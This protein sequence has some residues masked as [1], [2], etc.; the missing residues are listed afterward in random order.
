VSLILRRAPV[1]VPGSPLPAIIANGEYRRLGVKLSDRPKVAIRTFRDYLAG[2]P[3]L[4]LATMQPYDLPVVGVPIRNQGQLGDCVCNALISAV[5]EE[6]LFAGQTLQA[7]SPAALY[8]LVNGGSDNGSDPRDAITEWQSKGLCLASDVPPDTWI[9]A[10]DLPPAAMLTALRFR[11][12]ALAV[13][14]IA[15]FAELVTADWLGFGTTLTINVGD[16]FGPDSSGLVGVTNGPGNHQMAGG[17][18]YRR[19]NGRPQ[20]KLRQSWGEWGL[21]GY[22]YAEEPSILGQQ[23]PLMFAYRWVLSDPLDVTNPV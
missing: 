9:L 6:R 17:R 20:L 16:N 19:V 4:D 18:G 12:S 8:A 14:Q 1:G 22:C 11:G 7:F 15:N 21:A 3:I 2:N 10:A 5:E 13:Y 23:Q